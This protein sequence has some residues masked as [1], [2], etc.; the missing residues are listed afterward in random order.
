MNKGDI[1]TLPELA[2]AVGICTSDFRIEDIMA[3]GM[4]TCLKLQHPENISAFAVKLIR[5]ELMEDDL[6]WNRFYEELKLC[7]TLSESSGVMEAICLARLNEIPCL[8]SPWMKGGTLRTK[9]NSGDCSPNFVFCTLAR[10][11]RTLDWVDKK[12]NAVHRDLKPENILLDEKGL[13]YISDWGLAKLVDKQLRQAKSRTPPEGAITRPEATQAGSFLGTIFYASPE[14]ILGKP[15]IDLRSDIYSLG[16]I[17]FELESGRPPFTGRTV[18]E[19]ATH[20]LRDKAPGLGGG[21]FR[22]TN[23]GLE[24]IIERCL[25]KTPQDRFQNFE[26]LLGEIV[27]VGNKRHIDFSGS[28]PQLR[29]HRPV[30][31][32][33]EYKRYLETENIKDHSSGG[34]V[35]LLILK[36]YIEEYQALAALGQWEKA[37]DILAPLYVSEIA[38]PDSKW[39]M[40]HT[41]A[42]NYGLCLI[43]CSR[44]KEAI[45]IFAPL[46][47]MTDLPAE[48]FVNYSLA[49]LHT[50]DAITAEK[51]CEAGLKKTPTDK[52]LLGNYVLALH[53][54]NKLSE[55]LRYLEARL[56]GGRTVHSLEEAAAVMILLADEYGERDWLQYTNYLKKALKYLMEAKQQ[57]PR[58]LSA[59]YSLAL[60]LLDLEQHETAAEE[61]KEVAQLA[62]KNSILAE[63]AVSHI[64]RILLEAGSYKECVAF[65]QKWMPELN[66]STELNRAMAMALADGWFADKSGKPIVVPQAIEFFEKAVKRDNPRVEDYCYLAELYAR[67]SRYIEAGGLLKQAEEKYSRHWLIPY[68]KGLVNNRAGLKEEALQNLLLASRM[69]PLRSEPEWKMGQIYCAMGNY[70]LDE[71]SKKQAEQKRARRKAI[72][73]E[74]LTLA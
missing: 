37:K 59:R 17:M 5:P 9:M 3:G 43:K 49:L 12:H 13:A 6:A 45:H 54:Q 20:H 73:E 71:S 68:Y 39:N 31:G 36:P 40:G 56:K 62:G 23:L 4:G 28:Y 61:L 18:G 32:L 65:C 72:A 58:F 42:I 52:D 1:I 50:H 34:I 63:L 21:F 24:R 29:Q 26:E 51:I 70:E 25:L 30:V 11:L 27:R 14:Q 35:D 41:L 48:Y 38:K 69:A 74:G 7:F 46:A 55:A 16:C 67:M 22:R 15:E 64:G 47:K 33:G 8:C 66:D 10:V 57:N 44:A 19:V 53:S 2:G 60:V